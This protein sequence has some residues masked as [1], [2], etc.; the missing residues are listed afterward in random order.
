MASSTTFPGVPPSG[1]NAR[2]A[3]AADR[4]QITSLDRVA[5]NN[6]L[7]AIKGD[8]VSSP[9]GSARLSPLEMRSR[10]DSLIDAQV[11][12]GTLSQSQ[13]AQLRG[14]YSAAPA[15][16]QGSQQSEGD[17]PEPPPPPPPPPTPSTASSQETGA[18]A[19]LPKSDDPTPSAGDELDA[20]VQFMNLLRDKLSTSRSGYG[21]AAS[22][23]PVRR[24]PLIVD[25]LA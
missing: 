13:G 14:F 22:P 7:S 23:F 25:T 19:E 5:L 20:L 1:L 12:G 17:E 6:A 4:G 9:E 3:L 15:Q 10:I 11:A 24:S 21:S 18:A 8:F 16:E 2:I